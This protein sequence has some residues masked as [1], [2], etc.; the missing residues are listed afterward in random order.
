MFSVSKIK[1]VT[2]ASVIQYVYAI[3][4][5]VQTAVEA[6]VLCIDHSKRIASSFIFI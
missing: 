3:L 1:V 6:V 2:A 4:D 5:L